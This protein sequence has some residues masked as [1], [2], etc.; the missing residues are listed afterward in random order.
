M[1]AVSTTVTTDRILTRRT[2]SGVSASMPTSGA[3][4]APGLRST[5]VSV[6]HRDLAVFYSNH[7]GSELRIDLS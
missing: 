3:G 5:E 4:T 7:I 1:A 6:I 2:V